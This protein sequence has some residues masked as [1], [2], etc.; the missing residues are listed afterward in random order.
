LRRKE[1]KSPLPDDWSD[2]TRGLRDLVK[3]L[4]NLI[5]DVSCRWWPFLG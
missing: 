2:G 5:E 1:K 4:E 3:Q